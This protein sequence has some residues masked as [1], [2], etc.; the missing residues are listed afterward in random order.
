M[1]ASFIPPNM[2][3]TGKPKNDQGLCKLSAYTSLKMCKPKP[4]DTLNMLYNLHIKKS[5]KNMHIR[6]YCLT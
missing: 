5:I 3:G 4:L 6:V 1:C 2:Q